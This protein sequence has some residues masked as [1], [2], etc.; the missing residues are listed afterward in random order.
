M[1]RT[2]TGK[3]S[4]KLHAYLQERVDDVLARS[5]E[6]AIERHDASEASVDTVLQAVQSLPFLVE[7]KL[8]IISNIQAN[9]PLMERLA[10]LVERVAE[11]VEVLLVDP[12]L[13]K[14]KAGYKLL[15]KQTEL[16]DFVEPS[17]RDLP[18][19]LVAEA[20]RL[21]A[22]LSLADAQYLADRVGANQQLLAN[23]LQKLCTYEPKITRMTIELLTEQSLQSTIF[24]LLDAAFAGNVKKAVE[25]YREQRKARIEPHYILAM[26]VWQLQSLSLAVYASD[27]SE[28][29]LVATGMSPF[30]ARKV[31]ALARGKS[32]ADIKKMVVALTELDAQIKTSADAD[33]GVELYLMSL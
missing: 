2:L 3:N 14:R 18:G 13:D 15:Q 23:E 33:A 1:I 6:L 9:S 16:H 12:S 22:E 26:M 30:T 11:G 25:M 21:G 20:K 31:L 7:Q 8:V 17:S 19:W 29:S 28:G 5:G 10:E 4:Y 24:S 32:K 27:A